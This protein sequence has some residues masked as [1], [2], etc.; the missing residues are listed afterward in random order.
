M[1]ISILSLLLLKPIHVLLPL[2]VFEFSGY[3][4][5]DYQHSDRD[6][7]PLCSEE[8][9]QNKPMDRNLNALVFLQSVYSQS[10]DAG[11]GT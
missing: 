3:A 11:L 4:A 8:M 2:P 10:G 1:T 7:C 5:D 6:R 9:G